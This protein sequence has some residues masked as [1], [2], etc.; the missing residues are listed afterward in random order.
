[1]Q[2]KYLDF[3]HPADCCQLLQQSGLTSLDAVTLPSTGVDRSGIHVNHLRVHRNLPVQV[4]TV[5]LDHGQC[6]CRSWIG[7]AEVDLPLLLLLEELELLL[8][9]APRPAGL[10][11][12]LISPDAKVTGGTILPG[13]VGSPSW[14][15]VLPSGMATAGS[16]VSPGPAAVVGAVSRAGVS[17][18]SPNGVALIVYSEIKRICQ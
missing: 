1:M 3:E 17:P 15:L 16:E 4:I 6:Q 12:S 18:P 8:L 5:T 2:S 10:L 11:A 9:T 13:K 7:L 14:T